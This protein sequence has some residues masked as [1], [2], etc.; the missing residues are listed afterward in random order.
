MTFSPMGILAKSGEVRA[1][2]SAIASILMAGSFLVACSG[3]TDAAP[4]SAQVSPPPATPDPPPPPPPPPTS[5]SNVMNETGVVYG[6]GLVMGPEIDLLLDI[7]QPDGECGDPRPFV[8]GIHGGGFVGGSRNSQSWVTNM[9]AVAAEGLVGISIDY[10]LVGDEPIVSVEFL[11]VLDDIN[12]EADRLGLTAN[13][14]EVLNAAVAAMEDTVTA[15]RWAEDNAEER[16]LDMNRFAIWG[17]SAGAITALH[18]AHGLDEYFIDHPEP[19]VAIDYWGRLLL[20]GLV[21]L[22]GPPF[23]I[24]HGTADA[25][26]IYEET[27]VVLAAE[28]E[29][30]GLPFSFYTIEGGPHGFQSVNPNFVQIDDQAPLSVTIRFILDHL[31]DLQ[32]NY[33]VQT[34][35]PTQ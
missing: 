32:P 1:L 19:R 4:T 12:G 24:I 35:V 20:D 21:D 10:R 14:R 8:V 18:V 34:I 25:S 15:L 16:C 23:M 31:L 2:I 33:V 3:G 6:Q 17:S 28:A 5:A 9:E 11:S 13:Q 27:A 30:V 26:Q 22:D 29:A 7:Y